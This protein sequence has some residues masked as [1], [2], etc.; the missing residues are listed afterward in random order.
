M[1]FNMLNEPGYPQQ[2]PTAKKRPSDPYAWEEKAYPRR[3][4][5]LGMSAFQRFIVALV[6]FLL[7]AIVGIFLLIAFQKIV[8]P[9]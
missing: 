4:Q 2:E 5:F 6:L 7:I 1:E 8:P 9:L 3:K